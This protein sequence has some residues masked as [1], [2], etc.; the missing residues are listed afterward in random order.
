MANR[1]LLMSSTIW[2]ATPATAEVRVTQPLYTDIS[3]TSPIEVND[4]GK[5]L[6]LDKSYDIGYSCFPGMIVADILEIAQF[7]VFAGK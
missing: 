5:I 6:Y 2:D 4:C 7:A 1:Y 3:L